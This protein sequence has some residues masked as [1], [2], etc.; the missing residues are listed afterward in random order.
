M[1]A[2]LIANEIWNESGGKSN[3]KHA[4]TLA[5]VDSFNVHPIK[6]VKVVLS[7]SATSCRPIIAEMRFIYPTVLLVVIAIFLGD[8]NVG[9]DDDDDFFSEFIV[10]KFLPYAFRWYACCIFKYLFMFVYIRQAI[11]MDVHNTHAYVIIIE[12]M[13]ESYSY[14][15]SESDMNTSAVFC[16]TIIWPC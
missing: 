16:R 12:S 13:C 8:D 7:S 15:Y 14:S 2:P 1:R 6:S 10:E 3:A 5:F 11:S 4:H 9:D